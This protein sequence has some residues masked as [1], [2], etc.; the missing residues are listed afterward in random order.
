MSENPRPNTKT[1]MSA[2]I[3]PELKTILK[4][5]KIDIQKKN[6]TETLHTRAAQQVHAYLRMLLIRL[7]INDENDRQATQQ[8]LHKMLMYVKHVNESNNKNKTE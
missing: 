1:N 5:H 7:E 8:A 4:K 2:Q 3:T 6:T